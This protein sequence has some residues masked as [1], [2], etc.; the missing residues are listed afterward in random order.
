M[1]LIMQLSFVLFPRPKQRRRCFYFTFP[2]AVVFLFDLFFENNKRRLSRHDSSSNNNKS[3]YYL[4]RATIAEPEKYLARPFFFFLFD[5]RVPSRVSSQQRQQVGQSNRQKKGF[6]FAIS[7][8]EIYFLW[9]EETI[10][11]PS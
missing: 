2:V 10:K 11:K 9:K 8:K 5:A 3:V 7:S 6:Y 4:G 1:N